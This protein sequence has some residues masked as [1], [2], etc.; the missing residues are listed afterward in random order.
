MHLNESLLSPDSASFRLLTDEPALADNQP[1]LP[2]QSGER[3]WQKGPSRT[4]LTLWNCSLP[5]AVGEVT[6]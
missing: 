4:Q 5:T 2:L 6:L 1:L 3:E